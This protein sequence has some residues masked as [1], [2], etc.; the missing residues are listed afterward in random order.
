MLSDQD[1]WDCI[2]PYIHEEPDAW[3][4][5]SMLYVDEVPERYRVVPKNKTLYRG[6]PILKPDNMK[7]LS[8]RDRSPIV[9][10]TSSVSVARDFACGLYSEQPRR[11]M[12]A[13]SRYPKIGI[14]Y[15]RRVTS[16]NIWLSI[17]VFL[18]KCSLPLTKEDTLHKCENEYLVR[19]GSDVYTHDNVVWTTMKVF[20]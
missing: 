9:S 10:Y 12:S 5:L 11:S 2:R 20:D 19:R 7:N 17:G 8:F 1:I 16:E 4:M 13:R 3:D 14:V 6:M 18:R 15:K